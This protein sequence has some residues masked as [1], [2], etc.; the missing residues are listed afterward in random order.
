MKKKHLKIKGGYTI[1][2][3]MIAISLFLIIIMA[4]MGALLNANLLHQKSQSTRSI[5]DN[6]SFIMED[7]S[8]NLR[9]GYDF[10]CYDSTLLWN[11]SFAQTSGLNTPR[12]CAIGGVIVFE[13]AHGNTPLSDPA[14]PNATDQWAYKID[15][16][17]GVD[18]NISKSVDGGLNW[19][20]LNPEEVVINGISGF[21]VLGAEP[22]NL[23]PPPP[24]DQQQPFVIIRLI[25]KITFKD[26]VTP[27]S[28]QTSVSERVI[29]INI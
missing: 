19:V 7:M 10:R 13:E 12:S 29:D 23:N 24:G 18:F 14:D 21:S 3:T 2:E 25:G 1:I 22:P 28:L 8:R 26:V 17:N 20:Q 5:M 6:L 4:G 27:F 9:T 11:Q 15:S 16:T